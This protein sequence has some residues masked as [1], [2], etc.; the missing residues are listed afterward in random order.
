MEYN[1]EFSAEAEI[2]LH[3]ILCYFEALE[4]ADKFKTE[5]HAELTQIQENPFQYQVRYRDVRIGHLARFKY[6]IHFFVDEKS[7]IVLRI[8]NQ[9]QDY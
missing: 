1:L 3:T 4:I 8:L 9:A 2:E 7:I 5:F 6:S